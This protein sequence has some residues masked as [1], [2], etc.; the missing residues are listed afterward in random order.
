M[1]MNT[2]LLFPCSG[3]GTEKH[4]HTTKENNRM[5]QII[6]L[7]TLATLLSTAPAFSAEM[8]IGVVD[9]QR[10]VSE[11][12]EGVAARNE[13]FKKTEQFNAELKTIQTG[14]DKL[15]AELEKDGAA[16]KG[17]VRAEKEQQLQQMIRDFQKRQR[18]AQEELKQIEAD[19]LQKLVTKLAL[20]MGKIGDEGEYS[21][22]LEQRD[23]V[24][25]ISKKV[26]I[27]PLVIK[28]ADEAYAK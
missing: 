23:G 21:L 12:K 24:R 1:T 28:K 10:A 13:I 26:D 9:L 27:T 6:T 2:N 11:T 18:D 8:K 4:P 19:M 5:K 15:K 14:F 22:I 20:I 17:E 3:A 25:Y 16:M 7:L